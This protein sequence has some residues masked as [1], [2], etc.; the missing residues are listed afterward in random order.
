[1]SGNAGNKDGC[2][3][4]ELGKEAASHTWAGWLVRG[5]TCSL[6]ACSSGLILAEG[7]AP[8]APLVAA[9]GSALVAVGIFGTVFAGS[10]LVAVGTSGMLA[11][12]L[13]VAVGTSGLAAVLAA[14]SGFAAVVTFGAAAL[15]ACTLAL[16]QTPHHLGCALHW[17]H[18][19]GPHVGKSKAHRRTQGA[20][21]HNKLWHV[22][23]T[24]KIAPGVAVP[25]VEA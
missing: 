18:T 14:G 12:S 16:C 23:M 8:L 19:R 24:C 11:G 6:M 1:M 21:Q 15:L 20:P 10:V 9:V 5:A 4:C 2:A 17:T 22:H 7:I 3:S 13:S 25:C